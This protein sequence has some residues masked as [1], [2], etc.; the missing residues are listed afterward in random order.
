MGAK[1]FCEL[2][3]QPKLP[4]H[5]RKWV[6]RGKQIPTNGSRR[7]MMSTTTPRW[8]FHH[9]KKCARRRWGV[10]IYLLRFF[11][12]ELHLFGFH[13]LHF[14][15][16]KKR[17]RLH[18]DRCFHV[19][20]SVHLGYPVNT[21]ANTMDLQIPNFRGMQ[22]NSDSTREFWQVK[23]WFSGKKG[24]IFI[25]KSATTTYFKGFLRKNYFFIAMGQIC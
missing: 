12:L 15:Y 7:L 6:S 19:F 24:K 22:S 21:P 16:G 17:R 13:K 11:F 23:S 4:R 20:T 8:H 1:G 2:L 25:P 18:K 5:V 3:L 10:I 14:S 9:P